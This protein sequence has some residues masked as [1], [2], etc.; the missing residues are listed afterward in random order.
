MTISQK[1]R[2]ING[3]KSKEMKISCQILIDNEHGSFYQ[4][5]TNMRGRR[6]RIQ[7]EGSS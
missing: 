4:S 2:L 6:V 5:M 3:N 1:L 7:N